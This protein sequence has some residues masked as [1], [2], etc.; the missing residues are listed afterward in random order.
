[1]VSQGSTTETSTVGNNF[2]D[3][4]S[5]DENV[6]K[7]IELGHLGG[8]IEKIIKII[9]IYFSIILIQ[10]IYWN[11]LMDLDRKLRRLPRIERKYA[12]YLE[13][14]GDILEKMKRRKIYSNDKFFITINEF[15]YDI[16]EDVLD[17]IIWILS[18]NE[19]DFEEFIG[20]IFNSNRYEW[21]LR[22]NGI[23][24]QSIPEINHIHLFI[25]FK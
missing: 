16:E 25:R 11:E 10:M 20:R 7:H 19:I 24:N 23:E 4:I 2:A 6:P 18:D 9:F 15:G 1:M 17:L 21:I 14:R 3:V 8:L 22:E 13:K 12:Y 5:N